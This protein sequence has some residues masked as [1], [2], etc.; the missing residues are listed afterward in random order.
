MILDAICSHLF[1]LEA[2]CYKKNRN[3]H[4][5]EVVTMYQIVT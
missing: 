2:G 4:Y 1:L 3:L 5:L